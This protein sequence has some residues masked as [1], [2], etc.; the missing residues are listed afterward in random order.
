MRFLSPL[1]KP[2]VR[3]SCIRL[4]DWFH[5]Q[6][7]AARQCASGVAGARLSRLVVG[8]L[9]TFGAP[10]LCKLTV[11]QR[12]SRKIGQV[13]KLGSPWLEDGADDGQAEA[14]FG[15]FQGEGCS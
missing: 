15:G 7:S 6:L 3:I 1:I 9:F 14:V 4:S 12:W 13:L 10:L 8:Q 5:S 2:D 11:S